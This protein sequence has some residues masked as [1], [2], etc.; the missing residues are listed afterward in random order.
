[1]RVLVHCFP[2]W[3]RQFIGGL[4]IGADPHTRYHQHFFRIQIVSTSVLGFYAFP[5]LLKKVINDAEIG[6]DY[7]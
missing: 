4:S 3:L 1:M 5:N 2:K 6:S 7:I